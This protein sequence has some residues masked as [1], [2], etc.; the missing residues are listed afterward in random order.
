MEEATKL[1][2]DGP[3]EMLFDDDLV[4]TA[5]SKEEVNDIFNRWKVGIEQSGPKINILKT[6]SMV[7]GNTASS[8]VP[9]DV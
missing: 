2:R 6:K 1:A 4:L 5:E 9:E 7:T 8:V 3:W